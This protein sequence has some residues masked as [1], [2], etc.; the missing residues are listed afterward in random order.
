MTDVNESSKHVTTKTSQ[1]SFT[2]NPWTTC[3][4]LKASKLK[5]AASWGLAGRPR[6]QTQRSSVGMFWVQCERQSRIRLGETAQPRVTLG[7][8]LSLYLWTCLNHSSAICQSIIHRVGTCWNHVASFWKLLKSH[9][10]S[11][12]IGHSIPL[13]WTT[14]ALTARN[15]GRTCYEYSIKTMSLFFIISYFYIIIIWYNSAC[16]YLSHPMTNIYILYITIP[17]KFYNK[18]SIY[19]LVN[20]QKIQILQLFLP[21]EG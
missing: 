21:L 1:K 5:H 10:C 7:W 15:F 4:G 14:K 16:E 8:K 18:N 9:F 6:S 13:K 11:W 19:S 2:T 12:V 20:Q 3:T 17:S